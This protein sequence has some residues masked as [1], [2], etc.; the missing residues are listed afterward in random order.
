MSTAAGNDRAAVEEL[1]RQVLNNLEVV[2]QQLD[3]ALESI[4]RQ[5]ARLAREV[6]SSDEEVVKHCVPVHQRIL[7]LLAAQTPGVTDLRILTAL[8]HIV[9]GVVRIEAE[10]MKIAE[11][12]TVSVYE[13]PEDTALLHLIERVGGL[14]LSEVTLAKQ[15]FALRNVE[16][17]HDAVRADAELRA[18]NRRILGRAVEVRGGGEV[19]D[20]AMSLFLLACRLERIGDNAVDIA[21]Q[22]VIVDGDVH[23]PE[24]ASGW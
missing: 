9:R 1:E 23:K 21:E 15:A 16:V 8:L 5:D 6:V 19:R 24:I 20:W 2:I 4:T 22:T 12:A 7:S 10:C 11:L 3:R 13:E 18:L 14:S 17:A